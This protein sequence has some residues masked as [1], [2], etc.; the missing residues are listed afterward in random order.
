MSTP[1]DASGRSATLAAASSLKGLGGAALFATSFVASISLIVQNVGTLP[2]AALT[3]RSQSS[4][5]SISSFK[6]PGQAQVLGAVPFGAAQVIVRMP[7]FTTPGEADRLG[8]TYGMEL[9]GSYPAFGRYLFN[10]PQIRVEPAQTSG[11][12]LVFFP[13]RISPADINGY[14]TVNQL[15]VEHWYRARIVDGESPERIALVTLPRINPV[16]VDGV[17]GI[18]KANIPLHID[19]TR[20]SD[21][22]ASN[23]IHLISYDPATGTLLIKGPSFA[24][25]KPVVSAPP[26]RRV[27]TQHVVTPPASPAAGQLFVT[28][29][30]GTTAETA[31]AAIQQ[32]GAQM[33]SFD[34][35]TAIAVVNVT[36][37]NPTAVTTLLSAVASVKCVNTTAAA[38]CTSA[39]PAVTLPAITPASAPVAL[40]ILPDTSSFSGT[41]LLSADVQS[42]DGTP[43][44][45]GWTL[46]GPL[47]SVTIGTAPATPITGN[48]LAWTSTINF[49]STTVAD[50]AYT[51]TIR[52]QDGIGNVATVTRAVVVSNAKPAQ[53][54]GFAAASVPAGVALTWEQPAAANAA[55][56]RITRDGVQLV[57]LPVGS[58]SYLDATANAGAHSYQLVVVDQ[59]GA[60]SDPVTTAIAVAAP[61][62]AN[63]I[64]LV[65]R[66]AGGELLAADGLA[67]G[68]LILSASALQGSPALVFQYTS[69]GAS[70]MSVPASVT[71]AAQCTADWN[72]TGIAAGHYRVRAAGDQLLSD[73]ASFIVGAAPALPAPSELVATATTWG[74]DLHWTAPA[75]LIPPAYLVSRQ[76][77]DGW[78]ALAQSSALDY[79]DTSAVAGQ[80]Y[81]YRV[82]AIGS[83]GTAG[84]PSDTASI[85]LRG[86][87][88]GA[89][90]AAGLAAPSELRVIDGPG[91]ATLVWHPVT[92]ATGYVVERA[93][94]PAG[95]FVPLPAV[96]TPMFRDSAQRVGGQVFYRVR[97][98]GPRGAGEPS[99]VVAG[100]VLPGPSASTPAPFV[101]A[102]AA[103]QLPVST[104]QVELG[105]N[106]TAPV[107]AGNSVIVHAGGSTAGVDRADVQKLAG[108][109]WLTLLT[110][111]TTVTPAGWT[112]ASS[113]DLS[114]VGAG[115]LQLRA[116]AKSAEGET[117]A[118]TAASTVQV[119]HSAPVPTALRAS[120]SGTAV[121]L[122]W[123]PPASSTPLTY[124]VYRASG[125]GGYS[126]AASG[127]T[128]PTFDDHFLAGK[129][130]VSYVVTA[131]DDLGNQSAWS[132]PANLVT[133]AAWSQAAPTVQFV[134]PSSATL[135]AGDTALITATAGSARGV[136]SFSFAYSPQGS[137]VWIS[138]PDRFPLATGGPTV[139]GLLGLA[140][141]GALFR[142][143][144]LAAG[145]YTVRAVATD[146]AGH[147]SQVVRTLTVAASQSRG[148]PAPD[149][150][151]NATASVGAVHLVWNAA[152][153]SYQ[154]ERSTDGAAGPF[155]A[156]GTTTSNTFDDRLLVPGFAYTYRVVGLS[157]SSTVTATPL[158]AP[159]S[160][161]TSADQQVNVILPA[162]SA[163]QLNITVAPA[164]LT[165]SMASGMHVI[166]TAY[167]I[168]ATSL[169]SGAQVHLLDQA[170]TLT[171]T[172]PAGLSAAQAAGLAVYH[173]DG[174]LGVWRVEP[175]V[176]D[177][178]TGRITA[179]VSHFSIFSVADLLLTMTGPAT[180]GP[181]SN[182]TYV[183]TIWNNGPD[184]AASPNLVLVPPAHTSLVSFTQT[185]GPPA[186]TGV[187]GALATYTFD[188][189]LKIDA[190]TAV[191]T[192]IT[193]TVSITAA[194]S[195]PVLINNSATVSTLVALGLADLAVT[196]TGPATS[197][198]DV[199]TDYSI[200][201][202][203]NGPDAATDV[204]FGGANQ[205]PSGATNVFASASSSDAG[206]TCGG[207]LCT[208]ASLASSSSVSMILRLVFTLDTPNVAGTVLVF[209]SATSAT[210]DPNTANNEASQL[211]TVIP[212]IVATG[213][214]VSAV[215]GTIFSG[216]VASFTSSSASALASDFAATITWGDGTA[217]SAGAIAGAFG[218]FSVDGSHTYAEEGSYPIS[219]VVTAGGQ[220][221]D[222]GSTATVADAAL[223]ESPINVAA[224]EG[225]AFSGA[226]ATFSDANPN[227]TAAEF[228]A[229][230]NWGDTSSSAGTVVA[231]AL[232]GFTVNGAH[233]YAEEGNYSVTV[234]ITDAGGSTASAS[235]FASVA[236]AALTASGVNVVATE[237][238]V[239]SGA[240]ANL[241]DANPGG[242]VSDFTATIGWG[243]GTAPSVG[244]IALVSTGNFSVTGSHTYLEEGSYPVSVS[245]VDF[246]G[247]TAFATSAATVADAPILGANGTTINATQGVSFT[248]ELAG[249]AEANFN[250]T[251]TDWSAT[252]HWG[253][254]TPDSVG[255]MFQVGPQTFG[256]SGTHTYVT[257]GTFNYTVDLV[258]VGGTTGQVTGTAMVA[259]SVDL[260]IVK[261]GP[262]SVQAGGSITYTIT[263]TNN[264]S[265]AAENVLVR[266]NGLP[267]GTTLV[268]FVQTS[269]PANGTTLLAGGTMTFTLVITVPLGAADGTVLTNTATVEST[270]FD[271]DHANNASS[272]STTVINRA[273]VVVVKTG[274]ATARAGTDITY[275]ITVT[276]S[277]PSA[278]Q[279]VFLR[280][281][282]SS[283]VNLVP[284]SFIQTS[285]PTNGGTLPAGGT[286]TF[287][288]IV[289]VKP[290]IPGGRVIGN[291]AIVSSSTADPDPSN[292]SSTANTTVIG[293]ADVAVTFSGPATAIEGVSTDYTI[294]LTNNGPDT[295]TGVSFGGDH[296]VSN[297]ATNVAATASSS[298]VGV[299]CAGFTCTA[300]SVASGN[301]ISMIFS[302]IFSLVTPNV[303]GTNTVFVSGHSA[304]FD[305]NLADN[306][307]SQLI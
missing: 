174:A 144:G 39:P 270:T 24:P 52:I 251:L 140:T 153:A 237:G 170:A 6:L 76:T 239:F 83:D 183:I 158:A 227:G 55:L 139:A 31:S 133:P 290:N 79:T 278:A 102:S 80:S 155:K 166:G 179:T 92:G 99:A 132:T 269:G 67:G 9:V 293:Q 116:V 203:N 160:G 117:L 175:S 41:V 291:T 124:N 272:A 147:S 289:T 71:C 59:S 257:A 73:E 21:W 186:N 264:G 258:D 159:S 30:A 177:L 45:V 242:M 297:G 95:T 44:Q 302:L 275:T 50:G 236:D 196:F 276:N 35:T 94:D 33:V 141:W 103:G 104:G 223:T 8:Q 295:A 262:A 274:A 189:V 75:G 149:F 7:A 244:T 36:N 168:D 100:L 191:G 105:G 74:V 123:T 206:V 176:I 271:P 23:G 261:A 184:D 122:T 56:Y 215:E 88:T 58:T 248:A 48:P 190:G 254:G 81:S 57:E 136:N 167:E 172:L 220:S 259:P 13:P 18:W 247:S 28:F 17:R 27:V 84:T 125:L 65:V 12:A 202:T 108:T 40:R 26:A 152:G 238:A 218:A 260:S 157:T 213:T 299:S 198:E 234:M 267:P 288:L 43:G 86:S 29:A 70:W 16:L 106:L 161:T 173:W 110:L 64:T 229:S 15:K 61:I 250:A 129:L 154:V 53:P 46:S 304:A 63:Q 109:S 3:A 112:A 169:G 230:I 135:A 306:M 34:T 226:V 101:I 126:L 235:S 284:G 279:N 214:A 249:F 68:H 185:S 204:S 207:F 69:D 243:D 287:T 197:I 1:A 178:A 164:S 156:I 25:P 303:T 273:D 90:A 14:L 280:D 130:A 211:V 201:L 298:E 171:F 119:V 72:L 96:A 131:T 11:Q 22:A 281:S 66:L 82:Q 91:G 77:L 199:S 89:S 256:V 145:A 246:A 195:D 5:S 151:L 107:R 221:A 296:Q 282:L 115:D 233:T 225:I 120:S 255:A 292:N 113:I 228:T 37:G 294:T 32:A 111:A 209:V 205:V 301:S 38:P 137:S 210:F 114:G 193:N 121:S 307:D 182:A 194:T 240:V 146:T 222:A 62:A 245:I 212:T 181:G 118:T 150:T 85:S 51:L 252:I 134:L 216:Q 4:I 231:N 232:G 241:S 266:D 78:S 265:A 128:A 217:S 283:D 143:T 19:Q 47:A 305:P 142:T 148:P 208:A 2:Q 277:G 200:T 219:V 42:S 192:V 98:I 20:L 286:M 285:G 224:T 54:T 87:A 97:S 60:T 263:A 165:P 253:D 162:S 163:S 180:A 10:L 188:Y 138:L 268:S 300:A 93:L 49:D 187:L 127:L